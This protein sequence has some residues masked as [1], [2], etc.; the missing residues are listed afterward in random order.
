MRARSFGTIL[1]WSSRVGGDEIVEFGEVRIRVARTGTG[2][3]MVLD[4]KDGFVFE[5]NAGNRSIVQ[6][7][8]GD[9]CTCFGV[10][11]L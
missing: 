5:S 4:R 10:K 9:F 6:I 8:L 3:G 7:D 11:L 1:G 2:F